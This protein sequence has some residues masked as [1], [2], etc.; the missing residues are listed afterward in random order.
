[1]VILTLMVASLT[2]PITR[3]HSAWS[4]VVSVSPTS[5]SSIV[6]QSFILNISITNV[7]NL[8]AWQL[9]LIF[10]PAV[11]N[12]TSI[13]IPSDNIF[14]SY[15]IDIFMTIF[16]NTAGYARAFCGLNG[17]MGASGSGTLCQIGFTSKA[18]G[19]AILSIADKMQAPMGSYLQDPNYNLIP[20]DT[21]DG[22]IEVG[23]QGFQKNVFSAT[24][25]STTY[26][27]IVFSNSSITSFS[28][29]DTLKTMRFDAS[30]PVGTAGLAF[31]T[32]SKQLL[33]GIFAVLVNDTAISNALAGNTTHN[34][35]SF[36]YTHSTEHIKISLTIL[37]D[38]NGDR[39]VDMADIST[40]ID[41]FMTFPNDTK[42]NPLADI[43]KDN[44]VDM[45][46]ISF[47]T[48]NFLNM[49]NP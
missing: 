1:M 47:E 5:T 25:N 29:N 26:P 3:V 2:L 44:T 14:A 6:G 8:N 11:L 19:I 28:Y 37:G 13:S 15:A 32:M 4:T 18:P 22:V 49:W 9:Y 23:G 7:A 17:T 10:N 30:G 21:I 34:I 38:V 35:L 16:N 45:S 42:W 31:A 43:N 27:V 46:D 24:H 20:F 33:D 39:V 40:V 48:D 41:A 12:C 36:A